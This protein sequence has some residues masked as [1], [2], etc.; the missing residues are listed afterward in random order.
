MFVNAVFVLLPAPDV[1]EN[2]GNLFAF[3]GPCHR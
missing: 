3:D 2:V 1:S